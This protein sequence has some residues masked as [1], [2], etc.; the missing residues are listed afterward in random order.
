[1]SALTVDQDYWYV[2]Q[3]GDAAEM[4]TTSSFA[5]L[6]ST[7]ASLPAGGDYLVLMS[8]EGWTPVEKSGITNLV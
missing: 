6:I 2:Q 7:T 8:A 1:M 4:S 5:D 3:N